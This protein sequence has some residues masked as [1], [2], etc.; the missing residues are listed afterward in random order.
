LLLVTI[1]FDS[2][3]PLHTQLTEILRER[4][5]SGGLTSRV[6]SINTL[7]QEYEVSRRTAAHALTTLQDE[8]VIVAAKGKGFYITHPH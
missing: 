4:I 6:P 1:D 7:A 5:R 3:V 2:P 8:G